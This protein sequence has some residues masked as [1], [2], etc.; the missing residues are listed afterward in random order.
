ML[1]LSGSNR[2][3]SY[4]CPHRSVQFFQ[5]KVTR[6][7][8]RDSEMCGVSMGCGITIVCTPLFVIIGTLDTYLCMD[9]G[10]YLTI[11]RVLCSS[12]R[13]LSCKQAS[14]QECHQQRKKH[15]DSE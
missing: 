3:P 13:R 12:K 10:G 8:V 6:S 5:K 4:H 9:A 2:G 14:K 1:L 15:A 7:D 11:D